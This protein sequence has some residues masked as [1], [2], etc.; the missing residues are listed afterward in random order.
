MPAMFYHRNQDTLTDKQAE[1]Y[2]IQH[3]LMNEFISKQG[4]IE[5]FNQFQQRKQ[6]EAGNLVDWLKMWN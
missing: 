6:R 2:L 5:A 4:L 1:Y 3:K